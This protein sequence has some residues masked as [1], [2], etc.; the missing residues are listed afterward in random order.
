MSL[1]TGNVS[2]A[3]ASLLEGD[4]ID[5]V[6]PGTGAACAAEE[7]EGEELERGGEERDGGAVSEQEDGG[8]AEFPWVC[9]FTPLPCRTARQTGRR[10]KRALEIFER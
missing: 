8:G 9:R 3:R 5:T 1:S 7:R 10:G 2:R 6:S 4:R